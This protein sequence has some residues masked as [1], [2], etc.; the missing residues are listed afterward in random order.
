VELGLKG[1]VA[2]VAASSTGIGR[3]CALGLAAEGA[4]VACCARTV[5]ALEETAREIRRQTGAEVFALPTDLTKPEEIRRLVEAVTARF[6]RIDILVNNA[7]GPKPGTFADLTEQDWQEA[8]TLTLLSTL[9]LCG[10]VIPRMRQQRGGRVI[11]IMSVSIKQP[12][13]NLIL[14]NTLRAG[15]AG[16]AKSL[17]NEL[18][19]DGILVNTVCPGYTMTDRF[20]GVHRAAAAR[21]GIPVEEL[22]AARAKE[23]PLGRIGTPEELANLVVFLA[24]ERA[25]FIT[26]CTIPVDGGFT[27]GLL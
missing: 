20:L 1:K 2:L 10:A 25:S 11:N 19:R 8:I 3:A 16:L 24:S 6:G 23:V 18:G 9:R 21:Q 27:R 5:A 14:S 13:D 15:V 7:G 12:L 22:I 4:A 26:G 17:A